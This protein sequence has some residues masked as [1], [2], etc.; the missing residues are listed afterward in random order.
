M[1]I[2]IHNPELV[3]V[4]LVEDSDSDA[5]LMYKSLEKYKLKPKMERVKDGEEA[6]AYLKKEGEFANTDLPD[7]IFL[8]LNLP[9]VSGFDVLK[10][11]RQDELLST[12]PVVILSA[13]A[14]DQDVVKSYN[15]HAN[16][17]VTKPVDFKEFQ[18][19]ILTISDFWFTVVRIPHR[20]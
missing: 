14:S 5:V 20:K 13:S 2:A 3:H 9:K 15:L 4:L 12:I 6:I 17:Y 7:I 11:I 16:A 10:F 19:A 18:Q 8:D 1:K